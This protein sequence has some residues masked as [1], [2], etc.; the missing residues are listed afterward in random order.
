MIHLCTGCREVRLNQTELLHV[1]G[2]N[3]RYH[4][5]KATYGLSE[6]TVALTYDL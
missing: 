6:V 1:R 4:V 5:H 2:Q 3:L